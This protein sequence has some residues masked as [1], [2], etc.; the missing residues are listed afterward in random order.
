M[1]LCHFEAGL[2]KPLFLIAGH[3]GAWGEGPRMRGSTS[4]GV[5]GAGEGD[6]R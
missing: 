6:V 2:D 3:A 4:A 5:C 1:K